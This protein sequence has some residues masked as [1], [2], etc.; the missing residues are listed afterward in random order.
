MGS[1]S[2][3]EKAK[4]R[5][6]KQRIRT[7]ALGIFWDKGR[8][9]VN[10]SYDSAKQQYFYRA[11]GGSIEYGETGAQALVREIKE[12]LNAEIA[13]ARYLFTLENIFEYEGEIGH[14]IVL[15]Y[16]ATFIDETLYDREVLHGVEDCGEPIVA[17]WKSLDEFERTDSSEGGLILYPADYLEALKGIYKAPYV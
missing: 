3:K 1:K 2:K 12:E 11:L 5:A 16:D 10:K 7:L 4:K 8:I 6:K 13:N 17:M 9:L 14:E 15:F